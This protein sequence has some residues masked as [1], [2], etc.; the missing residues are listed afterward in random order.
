MSKGFFKQAW[1]KTSLS[2]SLK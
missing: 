2:P 1:L